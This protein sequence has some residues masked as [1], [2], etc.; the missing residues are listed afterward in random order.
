MAKVAENSAAWVVG[1]ADAEP[2]EDAE[3]D[4]DCDAEDDADADADGEPIDDEDGDGDWLE[5]P[6]GV[7][8]LQAVNAS[9]AI[10]TTADAVPI[11][12]TSGSSPRADAL[13]RPASIGP[14][15]DG[16]AVPEY[17]VGG[18]AGHTGT[19]PP[20][21]PQSSGCCW[22][23]SSRACSRSLNCTCCGSRR[24]TSGSIT[25]PWRPSTPAS[26]NQ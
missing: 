11:L 15:R 23:S 24:R 6:D 17:P 4:G 22:V 8:E 10:T 20:P 25:T 12:F 9:P 5:P 19:A 26:A 3:A 16:S 1:D 13:L 21:P 7:P 2:E 18:T 14:E